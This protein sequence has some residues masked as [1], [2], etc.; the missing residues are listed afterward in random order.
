MYEVVVATLWQMPKLNGKFQK[1][2]KKA[3]K[4]DAKISMET[5]ELTNNATQQSGLYYEVDEDKTAQN[6]LERE[7][8]ADN[9]KLKKEAGKIASKEALS[10]LISDAVEAKPKRKAKK[11]TK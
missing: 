7:E 9:L 11:E 1:E 8:W 6:Q 2:G 5:V 3:K 4:I 10:E